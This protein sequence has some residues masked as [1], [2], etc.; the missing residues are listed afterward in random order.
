MTLSASSISPAA[1][2]YTAR[3]R[4]SHSR[5]VLLQAFAKSTHESAASS[6]APFGMLNGSAASGV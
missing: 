2:W 3:A 4:A 6:K 1:K 5:T